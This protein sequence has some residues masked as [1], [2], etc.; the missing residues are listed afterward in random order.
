VSCSTGS[1]SSINRVIYRSAS[2]PP[3]SRSTAQRVVAAQDGAHVPPQSSVMSV[4]DISNSN[5]S[6]APTTRMSLGDVLSRRDDNTYAENTGTA[7][8]R[9]KSLNTVSIR[10]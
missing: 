6:S 2:A 9:K 7:A 10:T 4:G 8:L 1:A 5:A 3:R